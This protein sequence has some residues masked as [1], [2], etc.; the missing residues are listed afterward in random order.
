M[1]VSVIIATKNEEKNIEKCL[2]S[3]MDQSYPAEK[4]ETIV[5]DNNSG[6]LTKEIARK[7]TDKV[8]DRGPERS[9]QKNFGVRISKSEYFL[10]LDA[11]MTLGENVIRE[12]VEKIAGD[13]NIVA[14]YIPE[15][16]SGEKFFSRVRRF[17]RN[18]YDK[19]V[20]DGVRFIRKNKFMEAGGFDEKLYAFEDWDLDK[21]LKKLG[22]LDII[23]SPLFHNETEF[24]LKKYLAKKNYYSKNLDT[25]IAKWGENDPDIKKQFGFSYRFVG[26]FVENGKWRELFKHPFLA[27]GMYFLRILVGIEYITRKNFLNSKR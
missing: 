16:V 1:S 26:V 2:K 10:H 4:I 5:V 7:Y 25:Y 17:E 22:E 20:I 23:K 27:L 13:K 6:D 19:T 3:V 24:D 9:A 15:V 8:F 12:C 14:L 21:R 11:D 18:F